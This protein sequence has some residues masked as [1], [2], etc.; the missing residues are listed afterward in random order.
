MP[1]SRAALALTRSAVFTMAVAVAAGAG[2]PLAAQ[3]PVETRAG[4]I[5][6]EQAAKAAALRPY[7][8]AKAEALVMTAQEFLLASPSGLYPYFASVWSGGGFTL[9]AGYRQYYGDDTY[10][11]IKGLYS[12]KNYQFI[13]GSTR[14]PSL[15]EGRLDAGISAG[16]RS[17]GQV[18]YFGLGSTTTADARTNFGFTQGWVS[19]DLRARPAPWLVFGIGSGI[20]DFTL[21]EGAGDYPSIEE[22]H[23]LATAPGL[24]A[25]PQYLHTVASAGVDRRPSAGY[26]RTGGLY[27]IRYH[28][29]RD[30]DAV[31]TFD[32]IDA[33]IVQ[34]VPILRETWVLSLHGLLQTTLDGEVPHFLMPSV[35]GGS[36]LRG[37]DSWRYQDRHAVLMQ[38]E[39]RWTPNRHGL[40]MA[41]FYDAGT[42]AGTRDGLTLGNL[43]TDFGI[44][45]R[46][47]S[48]LAT[49]LRI[50]LAHGREG[51]RLVFSGS[52]AF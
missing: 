2:A 19:A 17:A 41:L 44:G 1:I 10:W 28:S 47:H 13:E 37:Y 24:G 29:Y 38:A 39:W 6:A 3:Q 21:R 5:A 16:W 31:Y 8:P 7:E 43:A 14:S 34:H 18:A 12:A 20:E 11:D 30:R 22:I 15:A 52:A 23:T 51:T 50:E 40:D 33:E 45:V 26:A 27:E 4:A 42:V 35:G 36:T 9:G 48:L 49:P 25:N 32:R 46:L